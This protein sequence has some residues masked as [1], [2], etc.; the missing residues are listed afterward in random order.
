MNYHSYDSYGSY[1]RY[2]GR[3]YSARSGSTYSG[4]IHADILRLEFSPSSPLFVLLSFGGDAPDDFR[5]AV[6]A[7]KALPSVDRKYVP[8]SHGWR[9]RLTSLIPLARRWPALSEALL[10]LGENYRREDRH[11]ST[12][13]HAPR[14]PANVAAAYAL[15]CLAPGC[16]LE[17]VQAAR[18][19]YA[20]LYHPDRCGASQG[21]ARMQAL[22]AAADTCEQWIEKHPAT[23]STTA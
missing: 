22:N 17:L 1:D 12:S 11:R 2:D 4:T 15:L 6:A 10:Q 7:I 5:Y 16:P 20:R 19:V 21:L 18:R 14:L 8:T 23:I 3:Y 13:A 9:V